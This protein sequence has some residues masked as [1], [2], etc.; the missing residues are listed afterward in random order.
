MYQTEHTSKEAVE[1][2]GNAAKK[3]TKSSLTFLKDV[4]KD[5]FKLAYV[6]NPVSKCKVTRFAGLGPA[7]QII[8]PTAQDQ[9]MIPRMTVPA[10]ITTPRKMH[11]RKTF[12][13]LEDHPPS[14]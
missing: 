12:V 11:K 5:I 9:A 6:K 1:A 14:H 8:E 4:G 10:T 13:L 3:A 7:N 2:F